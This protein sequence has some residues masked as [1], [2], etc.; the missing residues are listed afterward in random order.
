MFS[1]L[2]AIFKY[3]ETTLQHTHELRLFMIS[4]DIILQS[5]PQFTNF[6]YPDFFQ[7]YMNFSLLSYFLLSPL[8]SAIQRHLC[9]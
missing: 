2:V 8:L 6:F 1:L 7:F 9:I 4:F 3:M 5:T